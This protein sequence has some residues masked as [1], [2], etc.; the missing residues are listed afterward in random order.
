MCIMKKMNY[1]RNYRFYGAEFGSIVSSAL[2][3]KKKLNATSL[4]I[5][6]CLMTQDIFYVHFSASFMCLEFFK[7]A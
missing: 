4:K 7:L 1:L 5:L 2:K 3:Q 6:I